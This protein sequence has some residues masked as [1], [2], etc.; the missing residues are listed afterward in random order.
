MPLPERTLAFWTQK[1]LR[2]VEMIGIINRMFVGLYMKAAQWWLAWA[3]VVR[4]EIDQSEVEEEQ[5]AFDFDKLDSSIGAWRNMWS[6]VTM[7]RHL[8]T[9]LINGIW[10]PSSS[11]DRSNHM[12]PSSTPMVRS[13]GHAA[14]DGMLLLVLATTLTTLFAWEFLVGWW[15]F[16]LK[17]SARGNAAIRS[18]LYS[19]SQ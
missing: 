5:V 3:R 2:A 14:H 15:W 19:L 7:W 17:P 11:D 16:F 18:H 1:A 12:S 9:G 4:S 8:G 13:S 10:K 6:V